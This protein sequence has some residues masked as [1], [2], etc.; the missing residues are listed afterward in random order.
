MPEDFTCSCSSEKV[1][2]VFLRI[3]CKNVSQL[4]PELKH[5]NNLLWQCIILDVNRN[6]GFS[7]IGNE[8]QQNANMPGSHRPGMLVVNFLITTVL[9]PIRQV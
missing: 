9:L 1:K 5:D 8:K 2:S 7:P 4:K 3:S 6:V